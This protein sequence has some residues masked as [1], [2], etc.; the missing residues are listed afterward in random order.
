MK[1]NTNEEEIALNDKLIKIIHHNIKN[2]K[3]LSLKK[4]SGFV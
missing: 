1:K 3:Y 2:Y 4:P